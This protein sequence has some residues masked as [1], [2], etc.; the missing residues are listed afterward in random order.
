LWTVIAITQE[1]GKKYKVKW[2]GTDPKTNKP[3]PE[4]WVA[5]SDCTPDLVQEW[6]R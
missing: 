3:W 2:E 5:K 1:K 6:K 4:S